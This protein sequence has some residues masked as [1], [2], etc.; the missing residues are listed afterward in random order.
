[1]KKAP[2]V[3]IGKSVLLLDLEPQCSLSK[4]LSACLNLETNIQI[5]IQAN[6]FSKKGE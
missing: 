2:I 3:G 1:M 4:K 6:L 5:H